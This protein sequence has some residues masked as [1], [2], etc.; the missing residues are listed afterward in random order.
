MGT[1][2][3]GTGRPRDAK[4]RNFGWCSAA[5]GHSAAVHP[6]PIAAARPG[7]LET[8]KR[9]G[10]ITHRMDL[11]NTSEHIELRVVAQEV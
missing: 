9:S 5:L 2:T 4:F 7:N 8:A 6:S 11:N 1:E 3:S 10:K